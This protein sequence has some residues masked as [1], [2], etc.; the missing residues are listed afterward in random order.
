MGIV[1]NA[2][3]TGWIDSDNRNM[4]RNAMPMSAELEA[5][6]AE[7]DAGGLSIGATAA[8]VDSA[9][10]GAGVFEIDAATAGL[11]LV[12]KA[13]RF[14]NGLSTVSVASGT[15]A[16]TSSNTNYVEVDRAGTVSANTTAFTSGS[17]PLYTIVTGL[18]AITSTTSAK[19]LMTLPAL[20]TGAQLAT[21]GKTRCQE[22]Y[23]GT[24][25][26][27]TAIR[28]VM[29]QY[30]GTI[31]RVS[32]CVGTTVA[33]DD[34]NYWT[35]GVVNKGVAG[36]GTTVVVNSATAANSTKTTGGAV[37]TANV[38]RVLTLTGTGADLITAA[39]DVL[40]LTLT[41]AAS[42]ADLVGVTVRV[43]WT[44]AA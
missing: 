20:I 43:E 5:L 8:E 42:G 27:T 37:A 23:L 4:S 39:G 7:I 11:T 12:Y 26:A 34:T 3:E 10:K 40:L 44:F 35:A 15:L 1:Y 31:S 14:H 18:A 30:A 9:A 13:F 32:I 17:M 24:V 2:T 21:A 41:K 19:C 29:P 38:E 28:L 33:T 25:A 36:A 22:L 6:W 16:L